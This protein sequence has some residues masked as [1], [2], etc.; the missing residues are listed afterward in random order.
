MVSSR[1][2]RTRLQQIPIMTLPMTTFITQRAQQTITI[3]G[4]RYT[5]SEAKISASDGKSLLQ[6]KF[7][8]LYGKDSFYSSLADFLAEWFD[9]SNT[10]KV[11]T[12]GSTGQPKELWVEKR[13]MMNSAILTISFLKLH[14]G[15]SAMLCM[16]LQYIAGKM[17]VVRS[18]VAGLN[19]IPIPP[20]VHP[21]QNIETPPVFSAMIPMQVFNS[22]QVPSERKLLMQIQHLIIGGGAIDD[23]LGKALQEFPHAVWSTYGMTETLSHIALRRLNGPDA[24]PYY[25]PFPSVKLSLSTDDTLIIDAPLVTDE[26]LVTNDVA[27]LLPDGRFRIL[28]RKDNIINSGGIKI[29]TEI[30]EEI[31]RP[32][33]PTNFAI[34]SVPDPKFGEAMILLITTGNDHFP[35]KKTAS[36]LIGEQSLSLPENNLFSELEEMI[37][38]IL[39]KYQ[40]PKHILQIES[41]PLTGSGK[42]DRAAC[43][44]L[45]MERYTG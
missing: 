10:L 12:S 42:I 43:R 38:G 6:K 22:L 45:A 17:V 7:Y 14:Q 27:E 26:T 29:Q 34:T 13:K 33:I 21:M 8:D 4:E 19:L 41:I 18:L 1:R 15:D 23:A 44:K 24:S 32:I 2:K 35:S 28:G 9:D 16:P 30:V 20:C 3:N 36:S 25:T 39:P 40:R 11:H 37:F 31:L 5:A